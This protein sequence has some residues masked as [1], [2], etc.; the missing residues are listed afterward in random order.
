M[1]QSLPCVSEYRCPGQGYAISRAVHLG[2]LA[3]FY[4]LCQQCPHRHDTATF[5]ARRVRQLDAVHA[6]QPEPPWFDDEGIAGVGLN[7]LTRAAVRRLAAALGSLLRSGRLPGSA[8]RAVPAVVV[9]FDGRSATA[10]LLAA[11]SEGLRWAGCEAIE[12]GA[13]TAPCLA[14]AVDHLQAAGGLLIGNPSGHPHTAGMKF[15]GPGGFPLVAGGRLEQLQQAFEAGVD[16]PVRRYGPLN[17]FRADEPYLAAPAT[18]F[19]ALRPLRVVLRTT[20]G[21]ARDYLQSLV[22]PVACRMVWVAVGRERLGHETRAAAADLA[23]SVEDDGQRIAVFDE[24]GRAVLP[25]RLLLL[26]A[27]HRCRDHGGIVVLDSGVSRRVVDALRSQGIDVLG[28]VSG[29]AELERA[30]RGDGVVLGGD[31]G[32][33]LWH[34]EIGPPLPDALVSLALLL[35]VL[36][37]SD[38]P[39]SEVLDLAAP[40]G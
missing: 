13:V 30:V 25:E 21:P 12:V 17:R 39:L 6:G 4:P 37:V 10:A 40:L 38:R 22:R 31:A 19:H 36:S 32:G 16:R 28:A 15:W 27:R 34:C 1:T 35:E 9:G 7:T 2:R 3:R 18:H 14:Y 8:P 23:V 26:L 20:S 29:R 11:A 33:R 5:S 24:R